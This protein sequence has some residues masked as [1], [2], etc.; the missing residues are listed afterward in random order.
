MLAKVEKF[1]DFETTP[2]ATT[3]AFTAE[4]TAQFTFTNPANNGALGNYVVVDVETEIQVTLTGA[5]FSDPPVIWSIRPE[6]PDHVHTTIINGTPTLFVTVPPPT[7]YF[8]PWVFR[9]SVDTPAVGDTPGIIGIRSPNIFLTNSQPGQF[10]LVYS[11]TNGNFSLMDT[12][13]DPTQDGLISADELILVNAIVPTS[14]IVQ[15][16]L[17]EDPDDTSVNFAS[18][19]V[20]LSNSAVSDTITVTPIP[21]TNNQVL[22]GITPGAAGQSTGLLFQIV[23]NGVTFLSPDPI[24]INTTIGDG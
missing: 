23:Y 20:Q 15:L 24:L 13:S 12:N 2:I 8:A 11:S 18:P 14:F 17:K 1:P 3:L 4:P 7:H 9:I 6:G 5:T 22:I 19:P 16:Q 10:N 21:N